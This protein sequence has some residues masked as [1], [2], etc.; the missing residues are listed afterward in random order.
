MLSDI[1]YCLTSDNLD[2]LYLENEDFCNLEEVS[3]SANLYESLNNA[4]KKL[5]ELN[6]T[7]DLCFYK[8]IP[9]FYCAETDREDINKVLVEWFR[10]LSEISLDNYTVSVEEWD[11][12]MEK[13][14]RK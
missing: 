11:W 12:I 7:S 2:E 5:N 10:L 3:E 8:K 14:R 9:E 6:I 1:A 13:I 4:V